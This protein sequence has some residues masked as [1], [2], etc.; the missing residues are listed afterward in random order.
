M[1]HIVIGFNILME[2]TGADNTALLAHHITNKVIVVVVCTMKVAL[3][4]TDGSEQE[5]GLPRRFM[6]DLTRFLRLECT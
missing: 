3:M 4:Y 1:V 5:T 6:Q 2:S